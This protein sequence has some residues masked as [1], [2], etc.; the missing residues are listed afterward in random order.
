[1]QYQYPD[2][3]TAFA[4]NDVYIRGATG[5]TA[6]TTAGSYLSIADNAIKLDLQTGATANLAFGADKYDFIPILK[7][8]N[9]TGASAWQITGF[10]GPTQL[11][12]IPAFVNTV[13]PNLGQISV[14]PSAPP[15]AAPLL[16]GVGDGLTQA[17]NISAIGITEGSKTSLFNIETDSGGGSLTIGTQTFIT[18]QLTVS[19]IDVSTISGVNTINSASGNITIDATSGVTFT[20]NISARNIV[21]SFNG[22][23]GAI[24]ITAGSNITLTP[25]G[26]IITISSSGVTASTFTEGITAPSAPIKGD[27]WFNTVDGELYTAITDDS[28]VI[29]TQLNAGILGSNGATGPQGI[30]GNTGSNG[31]NGSTGATG[32]QGIQ[33]VTGATGPQG[34]TGATG[35]VDYAFVIAMAIAL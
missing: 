1:M 2:G 3:T 27:R 25:V 34:N 24:G 29:W 23:T 11:I 6:G 28:G 19:T 15:T 9:N 14:T 32:S 26:N 18:G 10:S 22:L 30:Q 16:M 12:S 20:G 31:T 5:A 21:N 8:Q 13:F 33:G 35:V 17:F 7:V 4:I